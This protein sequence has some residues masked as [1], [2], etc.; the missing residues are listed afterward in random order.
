MKSK[1][2]P[3]FDYSFGFNPTVFDVAL[4]PEEFHDKFWDHFIK[5]KFVHGGRKACH[6]L[7]SF[8]KNKTEFT[9]QCDC[10]TV[11]LYPPRKDRDGNYLV[12][13]IKKRDFDERKRGY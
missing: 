10:V 12:V 6:K 7:I 13:V 8:K 4:E 11:I 5:L 1:N 3:L 9:A 2:H